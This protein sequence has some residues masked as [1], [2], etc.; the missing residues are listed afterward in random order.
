MPT[1]RNEQT[2]KP[3]RLV[4]SRCGAVALGRTYLLPPLS[5]GGA[6]MV[7][8]WLRFHI[9]LI[10]PDTG[11]FPASG[12]RTRLHAFA[13]NAICSF[14]TFI[15]VDRFPNLQVLHHVLR[16]SLT[17]GP[18]LHRS[19]PASAVLRTSP[20]PQGAQPVPHGPPV[21]HR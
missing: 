13:C 6:S 2:V 18:S 8:P 7:P 1:A 3:T 12:S 21:G 20:P 5:F 10:E 9:P 4:E 19:Y 11:R 16:L 14:R 15:G 17:E